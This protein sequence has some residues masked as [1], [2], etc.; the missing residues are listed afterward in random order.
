[1]C[2]IL[3]TC[4]MADSIWA[5]LVHTQH[6]LCRCSNEGDCDKDNTS[7]KGVQG[8]TPLAATLTTWL[9]THCLS[10]GP[11]AM[12]GLRG[13]PWLWQG[14]PQANSTTCTANTE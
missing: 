6:K 7:L 13:L 10:H 12:W 9:P 5:M 8:Q 11:G 1:M 3:H 2:S 14:N 4:A